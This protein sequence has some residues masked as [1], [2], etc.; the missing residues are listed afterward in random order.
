MRTLLL[1]L[2]LTTVVMLGSPGCEKD[3]R[4]ANKG[5]TLQK[6]QQQQRRTQQKVADAYKAKSQGGARKTANTP[7][8]LFPHSTPQGGD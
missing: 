1:A 6:L 5:P 8:N 3:V 7:V 4:E 2:G